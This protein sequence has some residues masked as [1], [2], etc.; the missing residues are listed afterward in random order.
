MVWA[1]NKAVYTVCVVS[2]FVTVGEP[3]PFLHCGFS[4]ANM[5]VVLSLRYRDDWPPRDHEV[6]PD[7]P[8]GDVLPRARRNRH[9]GVRVRFGLGRVHPPWN[10]NEVRFN[11]HTRPS[12]PTHAS[13]DAR[14]STEEKFRL[15]GAQRNQTD[16]GPDIGQHRAVVACGRDG[17]WYIL[18]KLNIAAN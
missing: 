3:S 17:A 14:V 13:Q 16:H 5:V 7:P 10:K 8:R 6:A 11:L 15:E 1:G 9:R 12:A 18:G 2:L 4:D